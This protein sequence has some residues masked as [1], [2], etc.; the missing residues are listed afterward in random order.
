MSN[1]DV[2]GKTTQG[3]KDDAG[4]PMYNLL[5]ADALEEVVKVLTAGAIKYNEPIDQENWRLVSNPQSRYFAAAQR[6]LWADQKGEHIDSGEGGTNCYHLACAITSLLFK[7]QLRIEKDKQEKE[8]QEII[9]KLKLRKDNPA[10]ELYVRNLKDRVKAVKITR[11]PTG[12]I[13]WYQPSE[14]GRVF[15][16]DSEHADYYMVITEDGSRRVMYK[17]HCQEV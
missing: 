1:K 4:K 2:I 5:P 3:R 7:L 10:P 14:L 17:E 6:H 9:D 12:F 11:Y 13:P 15:P 16:V 8:H